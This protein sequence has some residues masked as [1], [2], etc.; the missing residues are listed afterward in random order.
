MITSDQVK[1]ALTHVMDPELGRSVMDLD[2][3]R[4]LEIRDSTVKFTLALTIPE[5]PLRDQI[6]A[7]AREA[8]QALP[9]VKQ[10]IVELGAMTEEE[11]NAVLGKSG[12]ESTKGA[13]FNHVGHVI[14]IA[15]GKGGVGK[16]SVT[17]LL[18]A[19][20]ARAGHRVGILDADVTGPS[21]P[22]LFGLHE[23]PRANYLGMLPPES[24]LG[25][26]II[27]VNLL[28]PS[29]DEAVIWRGPIISGVIKQFWNEVV[30]GDLDYLLVD[31]P[32]GTADAPL[33]VMQSLPLD[34]LV[35]VTTPQELAAMVVRKALRMSQQMNVPVLGLVE[36]M[37]GFICP[38]CGT[39]HDL[40]GPS[41]ANEI[42]E[43]PLW[44]RMPISPELAKLGDAGMI[45][46][47]QSEATDALATALLSAVPVLKREQPPQ[48]D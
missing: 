33:T 10:V 24:G 40:F 20:L 31:L 12:E 9:G 41:H 32:P 35:L 7:D 47:F 29:E 18:G 11:R 37:S 42:A 21:I 17:A 23:A 26:R 13:A 34:G 6:A 45:E 16:S 4:D 36:N 2:M 1:Q 44:A 8:V 46:S 48:T 14:A 39:R 28:L 22:R 43:A 5:C 3:L 38:T 27:S 19:A 25:I 15:S 30:W